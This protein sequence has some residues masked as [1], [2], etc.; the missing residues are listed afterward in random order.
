[1][2][3]IDSDGIDDS[4][5]TEIT[6]SP[7]TNYSVT[8][9]ANTG[10]GGFISGLFGGGDG[11]KTYHSCQ[12][13]SPISQRFKRGEQPMGWGTSSSNACLSAQQ[14]Q[15]KKTN[16][17]NKIGSIF[18]SINKGFQVGSEIGGPK[19]NSPQFDPNL[20]PGSTPPAKAGLGDPSKIIGW[21]L[22]AGVVMGLGY[23]AVKATSG[24]QPEFYND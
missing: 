16:T 4:I 18:D 20:N 3:D 14:I 21:V 8:E 24:P 1:M 13:G 11:M 2:V 10:G 6:A 12:N 17:W 7:A 15:Q 22:V 19:G 23:M 9:D 5:D